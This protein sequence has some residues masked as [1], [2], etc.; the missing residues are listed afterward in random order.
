MVWTPRL[1]VAAVVERNN[2]F[3]IVEEAINGIATLNQPAG[4]VEDGESITDAVIREV[5]EETA[6]QFNPQSIIGIYRWVHENGD[7]YIRVA[8]SGQVDNHNTNAIL[9]PDIDAVHWFGTDELRQP[10]FQPRL[11]SPLV[12]KCIRDYQAG[13]RYPLEIL[14][15]VI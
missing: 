7:T 3:L 14:Q 6:W 8:F 5:M 13:C 4:H 10:S 2:Q 1:T 15:D 11:R 9:D 12:L